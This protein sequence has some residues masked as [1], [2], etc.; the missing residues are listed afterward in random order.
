MLSP[1][2]SSPA[3]T[4]AATERFESSEDSRSDYLVSL[5]R[6]VGG[7]FEEWSAKLDTCRLDDT[8]VSQ[9]DRYR[10]KGLAKLMVSE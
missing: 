9:T 10:K 7:F 8:E 1:N 5:V 6:E 3:H 4:S 2:L